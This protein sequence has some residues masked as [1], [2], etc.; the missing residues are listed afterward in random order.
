MPC[1]HTA[2][3]PIFCEF[4]G[5]QVKESVGLETEGGSGVFPWE[6][7]LPAD[8]TVTLWSTTIIHLGL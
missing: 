5:I 1:I 7:C 6:P 4:A 8:A 2:G 3:S